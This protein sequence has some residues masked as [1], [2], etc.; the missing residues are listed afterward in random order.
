MMGASRVRYEVAAKTEATIH[1][2]IALTH[3]VAVQ[4]GLV[5]AINK[6]V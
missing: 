3:R 6:R 5:A 2:G 4:S 1:G